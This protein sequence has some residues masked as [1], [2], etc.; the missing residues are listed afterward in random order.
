MNYKLFSRENNL[1]SNTSSLS[2][3]HC[4][5]PENIE[6]IVERSV[7]YLGEDRKRMN[8][9]YSRAGFVLDLFEELDISF[10]KR[11]FG[12]I[13]LGKRRGGNIIL[14]GLQE[15]ISSF[16]TSTELLDFR[17]NRLEFDIR[18]RNSMGEYIIRS[19]SLVL[20][21]GGYGGSFDVTNNYRYENY[22][23]PNIVEARGGEIDNLECI[24]VHPFGYS[25][26]KRIL[27]GNESKGGEFVDSKG[28][29]VFDEFVRDKIK[30]NDYHEIFDKLLNQIKGCNNKGSKVYFE[31]KERRLDISPTVHYTAGGIR[32]NYV[33]E[34]YGCKNLYAIG[35]SRSDGSRN[36]GRFPGYPFTSSI[37][38]GR[39]LGELFSNLKI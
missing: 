27:I 33:G 14:R 15:N 16:E 34:V 9:V 28:E 18:L 4:R 35:E 23:A 6:E 31:D 30:R 10:E 20:A 1:L 3:G 37:V 19:K 38:Y 26:G 17:K 25:G 7:I 36:G 2:Y 24:F 32:T 22:D 5:V 39:I 12:Y 29:F 8:F 21:T 11:S 13:P